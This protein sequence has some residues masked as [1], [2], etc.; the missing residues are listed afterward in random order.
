MCH[1]KG[2]SITF[3]SAKFKSCT[4]V[5]TAGADVAFEECQSS[6][7]TN[8]SQGVSVFAHG[9][10]TKVVMHGGNIVGGTQGMTI[11]VRFPSCMMSLDSIHNDIILYNVHLLATVSAEHVRL[12]SFTCEESVC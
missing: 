10:D 9:T 7:D 3:S 6:F 4:V 1:G 8:V 2:C 12:C 5:A 11:Q